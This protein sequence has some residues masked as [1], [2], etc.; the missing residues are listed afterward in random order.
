M[1]AMEFLNAFSAQFVSS[2]ALQYAYSGP[3]TIPL[4]AVIIQWNQFKTG[5]EWN[6]YF[7]LE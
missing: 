6:R 4:D 5:T 1:E 7:L 3:K 2:L